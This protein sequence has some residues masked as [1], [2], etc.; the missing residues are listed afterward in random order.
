MRK[1][2]E[3]AR[4]DEF[5]GDRWRSRCSGFLSG[6]GIIKNDDAEDRQQHHGGESQKT[7]RRR[8]LIGQDGPIAIRII[9]RREYRRGEQADY[10]PA[11]E[12]AEMA[13]V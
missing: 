10:Q 3:A 12:P 8:N 9:R 6:E 4:G 1:F 2:Y 7:A 5:S 13:H 11:G